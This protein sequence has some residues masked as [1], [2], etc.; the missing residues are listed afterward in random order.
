VEKIHSRVTSS[1][2][3]AEAS[4]NEAEASGI[5]AEE[6]PKCVTSS[7]LETKRPWP[8][9]PPATTNSKSVSAAANP[10]PWKDSEGKDVLMEAFSL[11]KQLDP[12]LVNTLSASPAAGGCGGQSSGFCSCWWVCFVESLIC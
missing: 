9:P 6:T 5:E 11:A 12:L 1:E 10:T 3:E 4:E 7:S 2:R 8:T